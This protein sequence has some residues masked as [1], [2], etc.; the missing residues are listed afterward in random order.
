MLDAVGWR[1]AVCGRYGREVD[2]IRPLHKGGHPWAESNLQCLCRGCHIA[3][4]R[5]ENR[6]ERTPAERAWYRL[7]EE[8]REV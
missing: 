7:V 8:G 5:A 2:H 1:C 4:T 6:R 3:K